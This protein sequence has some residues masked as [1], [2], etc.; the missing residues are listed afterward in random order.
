MPNLK[1]IVVSLIVLFS[2]LA[3]T[4][5]IEE[6]TRTLDIV[7]VRY[8]Y[9]SFGNSAKTYVLTNETTFTIWGIHFIPTGNIILHLEDDSR[10]NLPRY[11]LISW[12]YA[13]D[14]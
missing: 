5:C 10:Y 2:A 12:E 14:Q 3:L 13:Y 1:V 9:A 7:E 8:S 6:T 11:N 4:G